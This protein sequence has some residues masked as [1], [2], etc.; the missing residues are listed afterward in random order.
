MRFGAVDVTYSQFIEDVSELAAG[1]LAF[2]IRSKD[3]VAAMML[4]SAE[5]VTLWFATM[6]IGAIWAPLNVRD[7]MYVV[8][9]H[10][11]LICVLD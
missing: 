4:N 9:R 7:C 6:W 5:M 2:G 3:V 11:Q 1:L 10:V 8:R